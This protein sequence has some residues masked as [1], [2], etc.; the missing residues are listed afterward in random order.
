MEWLGER[1][2]YRKEVIEHWESKVMKT[3]KKKLTEQSKKVAEITKK[4]VKTSQDKQDREDK[5]QKR[6]LQENARVRI[7][8]KRREELKGDGSRGESR[9]E[10]RRNAGRLLGVIPLLIHDEAG[11]SSVT[12]L[13]DPVCLDWSLLTSL[14]SLLLSYFVQSVSSFLF[15]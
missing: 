2:F 14:W 15:S 12:C 11:F 4:S 5:L 3:G 10:G 7:T 13:L 8:H 1:S 6:N 9:G